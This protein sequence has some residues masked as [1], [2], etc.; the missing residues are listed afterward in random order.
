M[1]G[2]IVCNALIVICT[3]VTVR[4]DI[5]KAGVNYVMRFFTIQSN[6]LCALSALLVLVLRLCGT[7]PNAA[8]VFKHVGTAAVAVTM[9]VVVFYLG[10]ISKNYFSLF[11]GTNFFLHFFIPVLA[12]VSLLLWDKPEGGFW[13]VLLGTLPIPLY[14]P[15]YTYKVLYAPESRRWDDFYRLSAGGKWWIGLS[16]M[17]LVNFILSLVLWLV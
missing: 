2:S 4:M 5:K 10:P 8:L 14:A 17:L 1:I 16:A 11:K 15:L 13:I 9:T 12:I 7:V 3:A 6:L